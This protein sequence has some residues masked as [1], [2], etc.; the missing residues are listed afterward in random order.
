MTSKQINRI[1]GIFFFI[2]GLLIWYFIPY[3]I[4][5][6]ELTKM[7]PRFFPRVIS[8][9][10]MVTSMALFLESFVKNKKELKIKNNEA[11]K[12]IFNINVKEEANIVLLFILMF[13]YAYLLPVLGFIFSSIIEM[14]IVLFFLKGR[15]WYLYL[16]LIALV[17]VIYHTF[18][19]LLYIQLP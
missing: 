12:E 8:I 10:L 14:G 6:P 18:E 13:T 9:I 3:Q 16:I 1:S 5:A 15:K 17:L 2:L 4:E 11:K 19:K 7:G